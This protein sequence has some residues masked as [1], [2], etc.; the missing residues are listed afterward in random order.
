MTEHERNLAAAF[1]GQAEQFERA[2]VQNNP[3]ALARLLEV[4]DLPAG[5]RV[6][7]AGCGPGLVSEALLRAG[8]GVWGVD[9]SA[10]MIARARRRCAPYGKRASFEQKSLF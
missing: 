1:D 4:A 3:A 5:G 10:E 6:L 9:L 2:S 7:D 8:Y